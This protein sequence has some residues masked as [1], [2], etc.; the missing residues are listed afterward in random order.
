MIALFIVGLLVLA[1]IVTGLFPPRLAPWFMLILI[2]EHISL[3]ATRI[4]II[5]WRPVRADIGVFLRGGIRVYAMAVLMFTTPST[6]TLETVLVW[7]AGG[8]MLSIAFAAISLSDL[9]AGTQGLSPR[10]GR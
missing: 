9:L 5:T 6:R 8:G 10:P 7:W 3:E 4:L 1:A 2:T